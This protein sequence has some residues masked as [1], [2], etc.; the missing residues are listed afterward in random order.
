MKTDLSSIFFLLLILLSVVFL[1]INFFLAPVLRLR[2]ALS[3][4]RRTIAPSDLRSISII[5]PAYNEEKGIGK[6][7]ETLSSALQRVD[8]DVEVIIGSDGSTDRTV[9]IATELLR[10][11]GN[12]KWQLV[13][14]SNEGKCKT[15]NKLVGLARGDVIIST[16]ADIP[17]PIDSIERAVQAFQADSYLGC[18]SCVPCFEGLEIGNQKSYW[19]IED[20]IRRAESGLG[21]LIVVTGMFYAYRKEL[22]EEIPTGVMADDLWIPLNVLLKG[23]NSVQAEGLLVPYEKTDE[24]NE[25]LRR[26]RVITGGMDVVRRLWP[27]LVKSPSIF[28]LVF[29][30]KVNR[31]AFPFWMLLFLLGTAVLFPWVLVA[32]TLGLGIVVC[33]LGGKRFFTLAYAG[34]SPLLSFVEVM[35]KKDFGRW[36][37]TRKH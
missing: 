27:R 30:H 8:L 37:H 9:E 21:R 26:K 10:K 2:N 31:W 32:Y 4:C 14:F 23:F 25:V 6:K 11:L 17:L 34:I 12:P 22:F 35:Q 19:S 33:F 18:L 7:I 15:I 36:Q 20:Q 3:G 28:W 5:V 13:E 24:E 1:A 16:D 29:F